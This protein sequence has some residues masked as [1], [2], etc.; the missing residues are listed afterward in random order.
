MLIETPTARVLLDAGPNEVA[1]QNAQ[2]LGVSLAP[3]DAVVLSHGN[4]DHTG[5]LASI[6]ARNGPTR[7][8]AHPRAFGPRFAVEAGKAERAIGPPLGREEYEEL[9]AR[10]ELTAEPV[11]LGD[12]LTTTGEVPQL[13]KPPY[14]TPGLLMSEGGRRVPDDFRDDISLV[15]DLGERVLVITGCAHAG[16]TNI[17]RRATNV[18]RGG[19][20]YALIGGTHLMAASDAQVQEMGRQLGRMGLQIIMPC[21]C[22]G[23]R[24]IE[25]LRR[26]FPGELIDIAG[27]S[28]VGFTRDGRV[29]TGV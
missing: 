4:Y 20:A 11:P 19:E 10:I 24:A 17:I 25:P 9:G 23:R 8:I 5:G 16:L 7:V 29:T 28:V 22:T 26:S 3:L 14:A 18:A 12:R 27:G 1:V 21:H 2:R 15:A 6:I 13:V